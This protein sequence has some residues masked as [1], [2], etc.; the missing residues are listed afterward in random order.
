MSE[1]LNISNGNSSPTKPKGYGRSLLANE[2][3]K[4]KNGLK[5]LD[6]L[7]NLVSHK[8]KQDDEFTIGDLIKKDGVDEK[9]QIKYW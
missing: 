1:Y 3:N 8:Q 9:K 4:F 2:K 5:E 7:K 6:S